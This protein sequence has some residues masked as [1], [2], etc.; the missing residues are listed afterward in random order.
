MFVMKCIH[1]VLLLSIGLQSFKA[2]DE[3]TDVNDNTE[4]TIVDEKVTE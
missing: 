4:P 3:V 1:V 2:Q